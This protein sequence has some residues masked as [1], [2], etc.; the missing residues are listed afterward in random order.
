MAVATGT[1]LAATAAATTAGGVMSARGSQE[2]A[3]TQ[4][5]AQE[6]AAEL[7]HQRYLQSRRDLAPYRL[8]G[9]GALYRQAD[10]LGLPRPTQLQIRQGQLPG[11]EAPDEGE[12][13]T[14]EQ[15]QL[16]GG[17]MGVDPS[18]FTTQ[19]D[20]EA[21]RQP[22]EFTEGGEPA[23][24]FG[25]RGLERLAREEFQTSPGYEFRLGEGMEA[26]ERSAAARGG[27]FSGKTLKDLSDYAQGQAASE[28]TDYFNRLR[29]QQGDYYNRIAGLA[30]TGGTAT[31]QI[32]SLGANLAR[33]QGQAIQGTGQA[34]AAGTAGKYS[35]YGQTLGGLARLGGAY[36][37]GAFGGGGS[38]LG[39][40]PQMMGPSR[41]NLQMMGNIT[42]VGA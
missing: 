10:L 38:P 29:A 8:T 39:G 16:F 23:P 34:R 9:T 40:N 6:R 26:I 32:S 5:K 1:A 13:L 12:A 30:G 33:S 14:E 37:G 22:L 19:D 4:A 41:P 17:F 36:A 27:L 24:G 42:S 21:Q 28:Y 25:P 15:A 31:R 11:G 2:A 3:E 35:A 20:L 18:E 7:M